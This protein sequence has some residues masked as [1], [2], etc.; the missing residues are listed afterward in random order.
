MPVGVLS[1]VYW[2]LGVMLLAFGVGEGPVVTASPLEPRDG[3]TVYAATCAACHQADGLGMPEKFPPL[4]GTDWVLGSEER[5]VRILLHGL[6][7]D[8]EVEGETFTGFMPTWGPLL[9]NDEVAA[10]LTY[11]RRSWGNKAPAVTPATVTRLRALHSSRLEPWTAAEL[12]ALEK[13]R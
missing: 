10:V 13:K 7:G 2:V 6:I 1:T 8:I 9:S 12:Q 4:V 11:V 3:A 5:L